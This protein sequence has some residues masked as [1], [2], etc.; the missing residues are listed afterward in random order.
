MKDISHEFYQGAKELTITICLMIFEDIVPKR[1][2][3][4]QFSTHFHPCIRSNG[5]QEIVSLSKD[6][7][8]CYFWNSVDAKTSFNF[9]LNMF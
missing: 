4:S 7:R 2:K 9:F 3:L 8:N 5:Q 6:R 1:E